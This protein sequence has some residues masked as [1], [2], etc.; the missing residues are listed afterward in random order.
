MKKKRQMECWK[1]VKA[2]LLIAVLLVSGF[3][4]MPQ[5]IYAKSLNINPNAETY[6]FDGDANY[7]LDETESKNLSGITPLG[8]LT[9]SGDVKSDG[10]ENN[11]DKLNVSEGN[12]TVTYQFGDLPTNEEEWHIVSDKTN[13]VNGEKLGEDIKQGAILIQ[14][15]L[16]GSTWIN[17][18]E[19][20]DYFAEKRTDPVYT[21]TEIQL[22]NGCY[23]RILVV[24]KEEMKTGS[25][26]VLFINTDETDTRKIAEVY[27]FYAV[28]EDARESE[29]SSPDKT[30][31]QVYEDKNLFV[32]AGKD[33]GYSEENSLTGKDVHY[34]WSIGTF[35]VNGYT[36]TQE[37]KDGSKVFLKNVGDQVTL[38]FSL[39]QDIDR[40]NGKDN[41]VISD[42]KNGYDQY[43]QTKKTD[44][45]RG[46][47]II[48]YTDSQN[49][50]NDPVIY[51]DYLA[52]CS[53]TSA[54]T[55]VVLYEEGDY[56]I[57]L[58]YE[59]KSTP[60][61]V[62]SVE[63]V[64]EYTNYRTFFKFSVHN[65]NAMLYPFDNV[66]GSELQNRA[67]TPNGFRIDLANSKDLDVFVTQTQITVNSNGKHIEDSRGTKAAKDGAEYT[68]EGIYTLDVKNTYTGQETTKTIYVGSDPFIIALSN[69]DLSVK[70][71]DQKLSDG[72][73]ITDDGK[74]VAPVVP[75]PEDEK[76]VNEAAEA[77]ESEKEAEKAEIEA[78]EAGKT[79]E[80]V[81]AET[82]SSSDAENEQS[83]ETGRSFPIAP[84]M[85][86]IVI[87]CA[88]IVILRKRA[89]GKKAEEINSNPGAED[90]NT[91]DVPKQEENIVSEEEKNAAENE[92]KDNEGGD[93]I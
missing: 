16:D 20:T 22:L 46:T 64:P 92:S 52:A 1:K 67:V 58:D 37:N 41:L 56:E 84:F 23:Y 80:A 3:V 10:K 86:I 78:T 6:L 72:Y 91:P 47:L 8:T 82:T 70:E 85:I 40:L 54:D 66:T 53:T 17:S 42:D 71:L 79:T 63:V 43:F 21:T 55:R 7:A 31:R 73:T 34:G 30:P 50:K 32:N 69:Y 44:M 65:S 83:K 15:S 90:N 12:L 33:T 26:K 24:Y 87:V 89:G 9:I 28:N 81:S 77:A 13:E 49:H 74:L 5:S 45:G 2:I 39:D 38:W 11:F 36:Q 27:E 19:I 61:K 29:V 68:K 18:G 25:K 4:V 76:E 62:G 88:A 35:T 57:A 75:E 59:I 14:T 51:T 60:R 48:R 93:D